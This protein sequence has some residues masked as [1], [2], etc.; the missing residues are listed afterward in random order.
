MGSYARFEHC[1]TTLEVETCPEFWPPGPLLGTGKQSRRGGEKKRPTRRD[2]SGQQRPICAAV[3]MQIGLCCADTAGR[4]WSDCT[5]PPV[6]SVTAAYGSALSARPGQPPPAEDSRQQRR[7]CVAVT[8]QMRRC[9]R[10][11]SPRRRV[12]LSARVIAEPNGRPGQA[13]EHAVANV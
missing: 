1:L 6:T 7:I 9:G 13:A 8:A 10:E 4:G 2:V 11:P 12:G 3:T 5:S